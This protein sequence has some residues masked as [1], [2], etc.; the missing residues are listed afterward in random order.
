MG[1]LRLFRAGIQTPKTDASE[2]NHRRL[3][4]SLAE[5]KTQVLNLSAQVGT[6]HIALHKHDE[7]I[8][9]C[10]DRTDRHD[11]ALMQLEQLVNSPPAPLPRYPNR[12]PPR[13][14][15]SLTGT[16]ALPSVEDPV[17]APPRKLD[18]DQFSEEQKRLLAVFFQNRDRRM[19]YVDVAA[20]LGKSR[21]T[22]KNQINEIRRKADL[23][24]C[25][26]GPQSR[27]FFRLKDDLKIEKQLKASRSPGRPM[28]L[29]EPDQSADERDPAS[30][31]RTFSHPLF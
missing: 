13:S 8:A 16:P 24:D 2:E 7:E 17:Y 9:Q 12:V 26:I 21:H 15:G 27:N 1:L 23:F 3:A 28:P 22:V 5:V 14:L 4:A 29:T 6:I 31:E 25:A 20:V 18:I 11:R 19:S 30:T 10:K